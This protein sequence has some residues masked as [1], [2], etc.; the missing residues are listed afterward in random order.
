MAKEEETR[1]SD[2]C[3]RLGEQGLKEKE[4]ELQKAMT[5]NEVNMTFLLVLGTVW[6]GD[7]YVQLFNE[8]HHQ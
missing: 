3:K 2:Q 1:L 4:E 8:E 5:A 6:C 7:F